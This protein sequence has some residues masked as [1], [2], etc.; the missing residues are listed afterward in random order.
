MIGIINWQVNLHGVAWVLIFEAASKQFQKHLKR[1]SLH[2]CHNDNNITSES[3][4]HKASKE[5]KTKLIEANT[6]INTSPFNSISL[7]L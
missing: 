2:A 5:I 6:S 7:L 1:K 4:L 3:K